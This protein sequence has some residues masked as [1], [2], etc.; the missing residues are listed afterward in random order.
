MTGM[1]E[2]GADGLG[3][4]SE[5]EVSPSRRMS[6]PASCM[7]CREPPSSV[8]R[9]ACRSAGCFSKHFVGYSATEGSRVRYREIKFRR[10]KQGR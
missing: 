6:N 4:Y 9:D 3:P 5:P 10:L 2:D 7:E 8:E 1:G